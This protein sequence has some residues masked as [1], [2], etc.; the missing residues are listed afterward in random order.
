MSLKV[1]MSSVVT[2]FSLSYWVKQLCE[3]NARQAN[4][5]QIIYVQSPLSKCTGRSFNSAW[6]KKVIYQ[7]TFSI[8]WSLVT[9]LADSYLFK[10]SYKKFTCR[11]VRLFCG[12][13]QIVHHE[14][15]DWVRWFEKQ[16]TSCLLPPEASDRNEIICMM[17]NRSD[18]KQGNW[19]Y[20]DFLYEV[21]E[22]LLFFKYSQNCN[23]I[24]K[25][26]SGSQNTVLTRGL[27]IKIM[28]FPLTKRD[29]RPRAIWKQ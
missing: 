18:N 15:W 28:N 12:C 8:L 25:S 5:K 4:N 14:H 1:A 17:P 26:R 21:Y 27:C 6:L 23:L 16:N 24:S 11:L 29:K 13:K 19:G 7:A 3:S 22:V 10:V 9:F 2:L 20:K